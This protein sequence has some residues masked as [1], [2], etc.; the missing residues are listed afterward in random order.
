MDSCDME[1]ALPVEGDCSLDGR[2]DRL[3]F[4]V[5]EVAGPCEAYRLTERHKEGDLA[6]KEDIDG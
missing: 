6:Y 4:P 5:L 2:D 3:V 1:T